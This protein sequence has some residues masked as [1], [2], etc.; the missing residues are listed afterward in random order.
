MFMNNSRTSYKIEVVVKPDTV[1]LWVHVKLVKAPLPHPCPIDLLPIVPRWCFCLLSV[2]L[3]PLFSLFLTFCSVCLEQPGGHLLG[4]SCP[5]GFPFVS[6]Y[7]SHI[8]RTPV[9]AIC[10]QQRRRSACAS[11]QSDQRLCWSLPRYYNSSSFYSQNFKPLPSF[12]GCAGWFESYLVANPEDRF[13]H[14]EA[15]LM[16][17]MVFVFL[18]YSMTKGSTWNWC[19][20]S[21]SLTF[22]LFSVKMNEW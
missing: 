22:H 18:P 8:M 10:D 7:M 21:W 13:S 15:H 2:S 4:K 12:Y 19:V 16:P 14:D 3:F 1:P 17:S 6:F 20:S 9:Y 5:L 11:A